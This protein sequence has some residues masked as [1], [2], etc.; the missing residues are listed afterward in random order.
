MTQRKK[1][2]S[3]VLNHPTLKNIIILLQFLTSII[4]P[5]SAVQC[6]FS[7]MTGLCD[8]LLTGLGSESVDLIVMS[9]TIF[10]Y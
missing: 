2:K 1:D 8:K 10:E 6:S 9:G 7:H 4:K 3:L 5:I